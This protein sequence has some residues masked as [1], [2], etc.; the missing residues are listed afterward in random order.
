LCAVALG[1]FGLLLPDSVD[2]LGFSG[3]AVLNALLAVGLYR[4]AVWGRFFGAAVCVL[5]FLLAFLF[6][7]GNAP[8]VPKPALICSVVI[9]GGGLFAFLGS[10]ELF[11]VNRVTHSEL[12]DEFEAR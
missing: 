1:V 4:R 7:A 2:K 9:A 8:L 3:L 6:A 11:G 10:P 5:V 12:K